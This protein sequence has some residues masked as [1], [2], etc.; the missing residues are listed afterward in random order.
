MNVDG[1]VTGINMAFTT[2]FGYTDDDIIGEHF[3]LLFTEED[4]KAGLPET[5]L[6]NVLSKGQG[7]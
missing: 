6:A 5:E 7:E 1:V 3:R 4:R 2:A